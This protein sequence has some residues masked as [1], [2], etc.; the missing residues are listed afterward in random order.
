MK[1]QEFWLGEAVELVQQNQNFMRNLGD[2]KNKQ[3]I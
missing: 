2:Q 1:E 3:E